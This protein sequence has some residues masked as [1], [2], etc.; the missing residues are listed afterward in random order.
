MGRLAYP[1]GSLA[2][3]G[4]A[5]PG[6]VV[7]ARALHPVTVAPTGDPGRTGEEAEPEIGEVDSGSG[8]A[9]RAT[10]DHRAGLAGAGG[11]QRLPTLTGL[12]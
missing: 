6:A 10:D 5:A 4:D 3:P 8:L 2:A 9:G 11:E 1:L 7:T 12:P